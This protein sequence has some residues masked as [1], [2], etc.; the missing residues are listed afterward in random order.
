MIEIESPVLAA[1]L[2]LSQNGEALI[3]ETRGPVSI[4]RNGS[5]TDT[6]NFTRSETYFQRRSTLAP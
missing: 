1:I 3:N 5:R 4:M 2:A 6:P